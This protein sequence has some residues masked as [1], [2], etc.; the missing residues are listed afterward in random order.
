MMLTMNGY[1]NSLKKLY[2]EEVITIEEEVNPAR[3]DV[4]AIL[5][6]LEM[7][8]CY[9]LVHFTRPLNLKGE[10]SEFPLVTNVFA[11]RERCA[12]AMGLDIS[13]HKLPL[14]LEYANRTACHLPSAVIPK[15]E[16]PVKQVVKVGDKA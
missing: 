14:S 2:P 9:P 6:H 4:T 16:A 3:F 5:Q 12:L 8:Q 7:A 13:Q 15:S 1:L 10:V 11:N